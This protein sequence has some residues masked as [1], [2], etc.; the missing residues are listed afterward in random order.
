MQTGT[1]LHHW[2]LFL[3]MALVPLLYGLGVVPLGWTAHT[4][5]VRMSI[6]D[7]GAVDRAFLGNFKE[8]RALL[9]G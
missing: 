9:F 4:T 6:S 1:L 5:R 3:M 7:E 2:P 8:L